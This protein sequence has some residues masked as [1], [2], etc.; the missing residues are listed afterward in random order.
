MYCSRLLIP[1]KKFWLRLES[2][3]SIR[4]CQFAAL[5]TW[6][7]GLDFFQN[8]FVMYFSKLSLNLGCYLSACLLRYILFVLNSLSYQLN[9]GEFRY[10][11]YGPNYSY[12]IA[13]SN[14]SLTRLLLK[15][16]EVNTPEKFL[17]WLL[18][19]ISTRFISSELFKFKFKFFFLLKIEFIVVPVTQSSHS[20]HHWIDIRW[21]ELV[22]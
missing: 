15:L 20:I 21:F 19:Y 10:E 5:T 18:F 16:D 9:V 7:S 1:P 3:S 22:S 17:I 13:S 14:K 12:L 11:E 6:P 4:D 2:N 8:L